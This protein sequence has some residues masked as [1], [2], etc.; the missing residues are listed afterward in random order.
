MSGAPAAVP[1]EHF[2]RTAQHGDPHAFNELVKRHFGATYAIAYSRL[3]TREA[4]E[5]LVQ[6]AFVRAYLNLNKL[7]DPQRFAAWICRITRNLA[8]TWL[9]SRQFR[10][11]VLPT[12]P[13]NDVPESPEFAGKAPSPLDKAIAHEHRELLNHAIMELPEDLREVVL[14]H[15]G[16][17]LSKKEIAELLGIHPA[18]VGRRIERA[19]EALQDALEPVLRQSAKSMTASPKA[20]ARAGAFV[21]GAAALPS[22]A[23]AAIGLGAAG[24]AAVGGGVLHSMLA[25]VTTTKFIA[26]ATTVVVLAGAGIAIQRNR[27]AD[28]RQQSRVSIPDRR[29]EA[30]TDL[31][32][33][34]STGDDAKRAI[35]ES[36]S[37]DPIAEVDSPATTFAWM[38]ENFVPPD[39]AYFPDDIEGGQVLDRLFKRVDRDR[40]PDQEILTTVRRGLR[41][42]GAKKDFV[43]RWVGRHFIEGQPKPDPGAVEL[44]YHALLLA[45]RYSLYFGLTDLPEKSTNILRV[46]AEICL[47]GEH[48]GLILF[49]EEDRK[50]LLPHFEAIA[51]DGDPAKRAVATRLA[52]HCK[53]EFDA[54]AWFKAQE[55]EKKRAELAR[56]A[57]KLQTQ[58]AET[59]GDW[60]LRAL[61]TLL[62][63]QT[64]EGPVTALLPQLKLCSTDPHDPVRR[65][66]AQVVAPVCLSQDAQRRAQALAITTALARDR[67]PW[68][69]YDAVHFG[70]SLMEPMP[71]EV[72]ALLI[73]TALTHHEGNLYSRIVWSLKAAD[74]ALLRQQLASRQKTGT[75]DRAALALLHEDLLE[76]SAPAEW[77]LAGALNQL[78]EDMFSMEVGSDAGISQDDVWAEFVKDL[79][80]GTPVKRYVPPAPGDPSETD[81]G[82]Q[83]VKISVLVTGEETSRV[84]DAAA[85]H[86]RLQYGPLLKVPRGYTLYLQENEQR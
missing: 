69:V 3:R 61:D 78:P 20:L 42:C 2:V 47:R 5:D 60:R 44:L 86:S 48:A 13:I 80:P 55:D 66:T 79:P 52:Q 18:N 81:Y 17:D 73:D 30:P 74:P 72:I 49:K 12:V 25:A 68:I 6:E 33:T 57:P 43:V 14:L 85:E 36:D 27:S 39:S 24:G 46:L 7:H 59:G 63:N 56:L 65:K 16:E 45:E 54:V 35:Q 62:A 51:K 41:R 40:Q 37:S 23:R 32:S 19:Q 9:S 67:N 28:R 4:A 15:Y 71:P 76:T 77:G 83:P 10:S 82:E 11:E 70:L 34:E 8:L 26:S 29:A 84:V 31:Y 38:S 75:Y 64:E 22:A 1:D 50:A 58:L 53:G 21:I